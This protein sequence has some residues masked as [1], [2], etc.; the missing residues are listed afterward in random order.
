MHADERRL[1]IHLR[2]SGAICGF[3]C[4]CHESA[5]VV[6]RF[7]HRLPKGTRLRGYRGRR[8]S[9]VRLGL[10]LIDAIDGADQFLDLQLRLAP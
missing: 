3:T 2:V 5:S 9:A 6:V 7:N 10:G 4:F 8:K 1:R